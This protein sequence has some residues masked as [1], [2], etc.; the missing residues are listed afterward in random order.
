MKRQVSFEETAE[1]YRFA[2]VEDESKAFE[3]SK[4]TL[5]FNSK[6]FYEIFFKGL[7]EAPDYELVESATK[8]EKTSKHVYSTVSNIFK[9]TCAKINPVWFSDKPSDAV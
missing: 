2:L 4:S 7:H 8:L 9:S 5:E 1:A 6:A 3:I